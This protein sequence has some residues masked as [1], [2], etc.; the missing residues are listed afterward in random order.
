MTTAD[1]LQLAEAIDANTHGLRLIDLSYARLRPAL[2]QGDRMPRAR[3]PLL[4]LY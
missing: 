2:P 1:M 3:K 4:I